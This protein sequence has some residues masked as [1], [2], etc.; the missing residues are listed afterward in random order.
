MKIRRRRRYGRF[1]P[2]LDPKSAAAESVEC[3]CCASLNLPLVECLGVARRRRVDDHKQPLFTFADRTVF[4]GA[5]LRADIDRRLT[6]DAPM[7]ENILEFPSIL[8]GK[9]YIVIQQGGSRC[10]GSHGPGHGRQ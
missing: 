5:I 4:V 6:R 1:R 9:E 2:H 7:T 3:R 8:I 10:P